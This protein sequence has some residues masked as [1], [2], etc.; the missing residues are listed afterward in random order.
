[1]MDGKHE[2]T[3]NGKNQ[4]GAE[5][6]NGNYFVVINSNNRDKKVLKLFKY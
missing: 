3:W 2:I 4:K 1:M 5:V 6:S